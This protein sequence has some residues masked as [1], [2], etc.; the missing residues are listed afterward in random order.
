MLGTH[1]KKAGAMYRP[2]LLVFK[3]AYAVT[4][5]AGDITVPR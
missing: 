5:P 3:I 2:G 1:V 4:G